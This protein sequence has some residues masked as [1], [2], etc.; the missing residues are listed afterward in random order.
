MELPEGDRSCEEEV[1]EH[2]CLRRRAHREPGVER[3]FPL[4]GQAD[5]ETPAHA[6]G[7]WA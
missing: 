2:V 7:T 3:R 6:G 5:H 4:L 1:V